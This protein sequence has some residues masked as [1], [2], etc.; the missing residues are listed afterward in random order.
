MNAQYHECINR[1]SQHIRDAYRLRRMRVLSKIEMTFAR[2]YIARAMSI[3]IT[4]VA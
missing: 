3:R 4:N 1:A 2:E